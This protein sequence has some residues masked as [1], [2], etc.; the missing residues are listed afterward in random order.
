MSVFLGIDIGTSGTKT[1][2]VRGD[3][4]LLGSAAVEYPLLTPRPGWSEQDPRH[5]ADAAVA[6]V[7]QLVNDGSVDPA[8][9]QGIGLSGQMHGSVFLDAQGEVIRPALLWNDQRTAAQCEAITDAA[10]G[11]EELI[12]MVANPALTGFT[13]P[14]ILWLR[15]EEPERFAQL[16]TVLLPKDYVRY[17]LTGEFATEVSDASGT[18]LLDVANRRWSDELL[19]KLNLDPG[20]LPPV[21]ESQEVTGRLTAAAAE[22][23]G[24]PAGVPVVGGGGDQAAGA[25]GNGIVRSGVVSAALGTSGVVFAHSDEMQF[26]PAGR[27]HTFCHAVPGKWH[28][29]GVI[30][31]AAGSLQWFRNQLCMDLGDFA[32]DRITQRAEEI[33]P[34][35]EGLYFLPYLSGERTPHAD[36]HARGAWVGLNLRTDRAALGRAVLEGVTY[37]MRDSLEIIQQLGVP[38]GEVRLSGGGAKSPFWR[39]LQ[40]DIYHEPC[41]VTNALEGPAYGAALLA[42]AGTGEY[43]SV[44]AACD[45]TISVTERITPNE[46]VAAQYDAL[47][48]AYGQLYQALKPHFAAAAE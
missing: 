7:R 26:D 48:P 1:L 42:M 4:T 35:C 27:A 20:L 2:A 13:A 34:G 22:A 17:R 25:V 44:E 14:K 18:L 38:I 16:K 19:A 8:E 21:Y 39:Q 23:M 30:L 41:T 10:G 29:M 6:T 3:G 12:R 31:S 43:E 36:P 5:W 15:D 37:A 33:P 28:V 32:F 11:R 9:V 45:A 47:Y 40:A 24:L 46:A